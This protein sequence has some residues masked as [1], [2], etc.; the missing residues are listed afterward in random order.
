MMYRMSPSIELLF[1]EF[2]DHPDRVRAAADHGFDAVEIWGLSGKDVPALGRAL[3]QAGVSLITLLVEPRA[4]FMLDPQHEPFFEGLRR[5][6]NAARDLGCGGVVV[7]SGVGNPG[8]KRAEQLR[9]LVDVFSRAAEITQGSGVTLLLENLNTRVDHPGVLLDLA[10]ECLEV[11]R[12][13]GAPSFRLLYDLYHSLTMGEDPSVVLKGSMD[14]V[15]HVQI[16]DVPGRG[17]PGSGDVDWAAR[18]AELRQL[19]YSGVIGLECTPTK[20]TVEAV[21]YIQDVAREA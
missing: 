9:R 13:V 12:G 21:R 5:S 14:L 6:V 1:T 20:P 3:E 8:I 2:G 16:A 19:G 7:S 18:L 10:S 17:E 15:S 11:I 4:Q